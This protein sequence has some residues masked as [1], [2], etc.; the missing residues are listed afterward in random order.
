V[1]TFFYFSFVYIKKSF[2]YSF[3]L[4]AIQDLD[5]STA[6]HILLTAAVCAGVAAVMA[7]LW[8]VLFKYFA[9]QL[10]YLSIAFSVLFTAAIGVVSFI[11]GPFPSVV[12]LPTCAPSLTLYF[13]LSIFFSFPFLFFFLI[14]ATSS[15]ASSSSSSLPSRLS[16][17]GCGEAASHSPLRCLRSCPSSFR[18]T[19]APPPSV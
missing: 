16:C 13:P 18:A 15:S 6:F 3:S 1:C 5:G 19:P 12:P 11:Y 7:G 8:L 9:K 10:I 2:I 14:Q 17:S 4:P